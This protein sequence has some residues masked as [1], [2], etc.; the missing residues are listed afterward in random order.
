MRR[1][2]EAHLAVL[3]RHMVEVI[4]I[5]AELAD[6]QTLRLVSWAIPAFIR[7]SNEGG[8]LRMMTENTFMPP[9]YE[10]AERARPY[11]RK[12]RELRDELNATGCYRAPL[13]EL[14]MGMSHD[15]DIAISAGAPV[16]RVGTA[17]FGARRRGGPT[18]A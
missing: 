13:T 18:A 1:M 5:Q 15:F 7:P 3:R 10:D 2:T 12:M 16:V 9:F 17:I 4:A 8:P 11:F 6:E 14:S